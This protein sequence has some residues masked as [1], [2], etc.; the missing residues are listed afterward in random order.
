M[1]FLAE[2]S[3]KYKESFI[4]GTRESQAEGL[5]LAYNLDRISKDFA[6]FLQALRDGSNRAKVPQGRVP[7]SDYWLIDGDEYIGRLSLR[8][9][10][11]NALL[12]WGGHIGYQI[13]PSKRRRGYGKEILR[14]GLL[15]AKERGL[16]RVLVTCDED[17]IGSR[18]IIEYN[19]GQL[20]NIIEVEDSPVRKMR[21]WID[22]L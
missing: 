22:I 16:K 11:N 10:L 13:R 2:P 21:Y 1:L 8:Y 19:G 12:L 18:K 17:N 6:A 5:E 4:A 9:E 14:L 3:L 15:K 7:M 20:E